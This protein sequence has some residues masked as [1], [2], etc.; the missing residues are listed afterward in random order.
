[1][2]PRNKKPR[3]VVCPIKEPPVDELPKII[4]TSFYGSEEETAKAENELYG[5]TRIK[6][7]K[8]K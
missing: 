6:P 1:M 5:S 7:P 4:I 8:P 2:K 3:S